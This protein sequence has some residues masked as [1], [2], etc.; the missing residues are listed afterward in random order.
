VVEPSPAIDDVIL[1]RSKVILEGAGDAEIDQYEHHFRQLV[2]GKYIGSPQERPIAPVMYLDLEGFPSVQDYSDR[3]RKIHKGNAVR[4]ALRAGRKGY[5]STFFSH[6][7]HLADI[8]EIS[9]SA[10]E[11]QGRPLPEGYFLTAEQWGGYPTA[12]EPERVPTDAL[13]WERY[14][15]L[16]LSRPGH[17]QG[18][19]S[20]DE[21][22]IAYAHLRRVGETVWLNRF[23][24][25]AAHLVHGIMHKVHIDLVE[26]VL[27][28]RDGSGVDQSLRGLRYLINGGYLGLL[29]DGVLGRSGGDGLLR[30]K[31]RM[32]YRPGLLIYQE[33]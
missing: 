26:R 25:H 19:L 10:P 8:L 29:P 9:Q 28:G 16:F 30:W 14:F 3:C 13:S 24:G 22:L 20:L 1:R 33:T 12:V 6:R 11:R 23:I 7:N 2:E 32:L 31:Q 21:R 17:R 15:G 27:A 5:Y 4:D 18:P